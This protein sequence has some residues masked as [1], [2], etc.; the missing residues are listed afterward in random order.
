MKNPWNDIISLLPLQEFMSLTSIQ[1][2]LYASAPC[3]IFYAISLHVAWILHQVPPK[4]FCLSIY[5][6][7]M[8]ALAPT[9][10]QVSPLLS[11]SSIS[12]LSVHSYDVAMVDLSLLDIYHIGAIFLFAF[13]PL[14]ILETTI[15]LD[16]SVL[17]NNLYIVL[18]PQMR[19]LDY[20]SLPI[21][22]PLHRSRPSN[23]LNLLHISVSYGR[24][25][26]MLKRKF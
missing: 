8:V 20:N 19:L 12:T 1:G 4:L 3:F 15:P 6:E 13:F 9:I 18:S 17:L 24:S 26:S 16:Y 7:L 23:M 25:L 14:E 11:L 21:Q 10:P 5:I 22:P 2:K